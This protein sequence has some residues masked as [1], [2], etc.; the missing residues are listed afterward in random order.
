[1]RRLLFIL[2]TLPFTA[3]AAE[4]SA[5][6]GSGYAAVEGSVVNYTYN[7]FGGFYLTVEDNLIRWEGFHGY[8]NGLVSANPPQ[9]SEL[10]PDVFLYSW[11][12]RGNGSDNVV[13]NYNTARVTAHL[14]PDDGAG[15]AIQMI[16]GVIHFRNTPNCIEPSTKLTP[17][18]EFPKRMG[19]TINEFGLPPLF[20][21]EVNNTAVALADKQ[22]REDL[23]GKMI[24]YTTP[25]GEYRIEVDGNTTRVSINGGDP[26]DHQTYA[27]KIADDLY[28]VS[29]MGGIGGS[30]VAVNTTTRKV[31]DHIL[32]N[33]E[34]R[35]SVFVLTCFDAREKC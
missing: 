9:I 31:Y 4:P 1:M 22:A 30:H 8:F 3:Q 16:H 11:R 5:F 25:E 18:A 7:N 13:H 6:S 15:D 12:T 23:A 26:E 34:R 32:P 33:G 2:F 17:R 19:A 10:A 20:K 24:V 21:P 14:Q 28:F 29:W 35:E 27:S